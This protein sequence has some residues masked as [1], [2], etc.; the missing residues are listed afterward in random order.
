MAGSYIPSREGELAP[1]A[2]NFDT[3]VTAAPAMYGLAAPDAV[4]I[5]SYVSAFTAALTLASDPVTRTL[6]T[7]VD[8][9][10]KKAAMLDVL[11]SYAQRI[12]ANAGVADADKANLGIN[13]NPR[14]TTPVPTPT[15]FP[16]VALSIPA[17][18]R[19]EC[20]VADSATP[21]SSA[22]PRGVIGAQV[23]VSTAANPPTDVTTWRF[24][25]FATRRTFTLDFDGDEAGKVAH[26]AMRWQTR[27]GD[28]SPWSA[29]QSTFVVGM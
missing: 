2:V 27:R 29:T 14:T 13:V 18:L 26:V 12:K 19:I 20:R 21:D 24:A 9:D 3:L 4:S 1:W 16:T 8:K 11:R 15:T 22:K 7:I 28:V 25:G 17:A 10:S 5:H 6:G 23:F